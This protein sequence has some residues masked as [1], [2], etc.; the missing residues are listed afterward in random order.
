MSSKIKRAKLLAMF[1]HWGQERQDKE[2]YINHC[3]RVAYQVSLLESSTEDMVIAAW[4]HDCIEDSNNQVAIQSIIQSSFSEK[5]YS[6]VTIL[7]QKKW[8]T[9]NEYIERVV[10][11]PQ[12]LQIKW[13]DMIDNT[14]YPIP[15]K[16]WTKY[17]D[18]CIFLE[19][20]E[21][22]IPKILIERLKL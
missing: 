1:V 15:K 11:D 18:A 9:Y 20:K 4:I 13:T 17:R 12:A 16:Q 14:S 22:E 8:Q 21:I 10:E 2:D 5:S 3:Q 19:R 7:T 6:L